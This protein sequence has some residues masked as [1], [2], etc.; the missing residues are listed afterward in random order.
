[1]KKITSPL[2]GGFDPS[3]VPYESLEW[4]SEKVSYTD[5]PQLMEST[6]R[7][8]R[9]FIVEDRVY[10]ETMPELGHK[11]V[12]NETVRPV[13]NEAFDAEREEPVVLIRM[14][15]SG[16][17]VVHLPKISDVTESVLVRVALFARELGVSE[18]AFVEWSESGVIVKD[19]VGEYYDQF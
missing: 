8:G 14:S 19:R 9:A 6:I 13:E 11:S 12:W 5:L 16:S 7:A 10:L 18:D 17:L 1:M 15:P 2:N 3:V 4:Q